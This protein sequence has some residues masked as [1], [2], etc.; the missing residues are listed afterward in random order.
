MLEEKR[1]GICIVDL[2]GVLFDVSRRL[3]IAKQ[4]AR[5]N[6]NR[7]WEIFL[8]EDLLDLDIPR[9]AGIEILQR[10]I[11]RN[12]EILILTGRP[13]HLL[14]KT[15]EQLSKIG[16]EL[17][18]GIYIIMRPSKKTRN[19]NPYRP[20]INIPR[21]HEMIDTRLFKV[22]IIERVA[23]TYNIAEI[24]E[25]DE[26]ILR[27]VEKRYPG[28]ILYLHVGD[29]YREYRRARDLT[30]FSSKNSTSS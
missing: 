2:D 30:S 22:K 4:E 26:D 12:L 6:R 7:F 15:V 28:I 29:S 9:K 14:D 10:C 11:G 19:R 27:E 25:D 21:L 3:S 24:H 1:R 20:P 18:R 17:G 16:V 23:E 5:G 13:E 8:R